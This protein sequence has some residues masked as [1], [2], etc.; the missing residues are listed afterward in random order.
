MGNSF[1]ERGEFRRREGC[2]QVQFDPCLFRRR[3]HPLHCVDCR[4]A[5][6]LVA[7][8]RLVHEREHDALHAGAARLPQQPSQL[9]DAFRTLRIGGADEGKVHE[10]VG[11]Y[12]AYGNPVKFRQI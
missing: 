4:V 11:A 5:V 1:Q 8:R 3:Q 10:V 12:G 9:H 7:N 6:G 2:L